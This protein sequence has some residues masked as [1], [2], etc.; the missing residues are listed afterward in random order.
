VL[1][2]AL[3]KRELRPII[4]CEFSHAMGNSCGS[5]DAYFAMLD[6]PDRAFRQVQGG[7]IWDWADLTVKLPGFLEGNRGVG[8][9][10]GPQSGAGDGFFCCNGIVTAD[11]Q[12]KPTL[13]ELGHLQQELQLAME[14]NG[15][16]GRLEVRGERYFSRIFIRY[17]YFSHIFAY[18]F[19]FK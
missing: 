1:S 16:Q 17:A 14:R 5:L 11:R 18:L 3:D 9:D 7:F 8:G 10:F 12:P 2:T 4:Q 13:L 19:F 6:S 15:V